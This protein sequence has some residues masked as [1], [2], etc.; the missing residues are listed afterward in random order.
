MHPTDLL[1]H[2]L[3]VDLR[4]VLSGAG[5]PETEYG[6]TP[7]RP[8]FALKPTAGGH[9]VEVC[10]F[11]STSQNAECLRRNRETMLTAMGMI[12]RGEQYFFSWS[13]DLYERDCLDVSGGPDRVHDYFQLLIDLQR[14]HASSARV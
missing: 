13:Q 8:G 2:A 11:P 12:L 7:Q 9:T 10:W 4:A 6:R 1:Q 14:T 5:L 3:V